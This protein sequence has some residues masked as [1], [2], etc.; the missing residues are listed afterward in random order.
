MAPFDARVLDNPTYSSLTGRH[1]HL[2]ERIG[3]AARYPADIVPF[4]ALPDQPTAND[5]DSLR[6]LVGADQA[7][8]LVRAEL[9]VPS[10]WSTAVRMPCLQMVA[11]PEWPDGTDSTHVVAPI[12]DFAALDSLVGAA[13]PGPWLARTSEL[14]GYVGVDEDG[15]LVAAAGYR[16]APDGA[17][18]ISAV[19]T[20]VEHR[21]RGLARSVVRR[22]AEGIRDAGDVPFLHVVPDNTSAIRSYERLGFAVRRQL[23]VVVVTA[24]A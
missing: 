21:G 15:R 2:A 7:A 17:R 1:A 6:Q 20:A 22:V 14:G 8:V 16:L 11:P 12:T 23:E 13:R 4:G 10:P 3:T 9:Q 19:S 18:E 24:P 5:W